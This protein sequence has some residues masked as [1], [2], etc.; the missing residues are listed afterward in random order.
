M[1][2]L[3]PPMRNLERSTRNMDSSTHIAH[4]SEQIV[5]GAVQIAFA[6]GCVCIDGFSHPS[7]VAVV[8][9]TPPCG[10]GVFGVGVKSITIMTKTSK[11][12]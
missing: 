5:Y 3:D 12:L 11:S 1:H 7:G 2:D 9:P 6:L 4:G 8:P 10:G